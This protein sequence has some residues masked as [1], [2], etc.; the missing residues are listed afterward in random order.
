CRSEFGESHLLGFRLRT[1]WRDEIGAG[2]T[3]QRGLERAGIVEVAHDDRRGGLR[4]P[5]GV[6]GGANHR[7]NERAALLEFLEHGRSRIPRS[8]GDENQ[9]FRR[10]GGPL[11]SY[12][13]LMIVDSPE[14]AR[15]AVGNNSGEH[16]DRTHLTNGTYAG[17]VRRYCAN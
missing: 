17:V 10:H 13:S 6:L 4:Q 8:T 3:L 16:E 12:R 9:I 11:L 15:R 14:V 5:R 1:R 2:D 7:A